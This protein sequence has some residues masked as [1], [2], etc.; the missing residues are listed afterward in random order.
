MQQMWEN[1]ILYTT[2]LREVRINEVSHSLSSRGLIRATHETQLQQLEA[3]TIVPLLCSIKH[4][5]STKQVRLPDD[6]TEHVEF[7][8]RN[9]T[10]GSVSQ[11]DKYFFV[12]VHHFLHDF[13]AFAKDFVW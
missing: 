9:V 7:L 1:L 4:Y 5:A 13:V 8:H 11:D 12:V 2:N 3:D 6:T 10:T